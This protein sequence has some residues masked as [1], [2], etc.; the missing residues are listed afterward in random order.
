MCAVL[1]VHVGNIFYP[2]FKQ[3]SIRV[4]WAKTELWT[5][6]MI[7]CKLDTVKGFPEKEKGESAGHAQTLQ[8]NSMSMLVGH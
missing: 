8:P 5:L 7:A 1:V 3:S 4:G 2:V 6:Q